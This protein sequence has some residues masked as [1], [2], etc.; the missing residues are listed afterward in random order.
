[1]KYSKNQIKK[2]GKIFKEKLAASEE[3][4]NFAAEVL[5]YWRIIHGQAIINFQ[6][7][8]IENVFDVDDKAFIAKR[9]KRTPS[10]IAKLKRL[11]HIQLSTM[12]DIAG[13]RVVVSSLTHLRKLVKILKSDSFG[14][15]LKGEDDY[16]SN[17]KESGYRGIH[18]IYK[19]KDENVQ[20]LDGLIIEVQVR[21]HKQHA[22]ATA[23][24]TMGTYLNSHLKFNEGKPKWLKYFALTSSAF[25][26]IEKTKPV[27]QY[28]KLTE[29]ETYQQAVY[30][31]KYN[32][33]KESLEAFSLVSNFICDETRKDHKY[34]LI[35][36][37]IKERI[38]E[39][40]SYR[41]D[42]LEDANKDYTEFEGKYE[43]DSNVQIVLVS[44]DTIQEL[45]EAYPNYFLDTKEFIRNMKLIEKR[46]N[47]LKTKIY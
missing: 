28:N 15:E 43:T 12:Q 21:T 36:L 7:K 32:E 41:E 33:I 27:P 18:L 37:K 20:E 26:Y 46:F 11:N 30:E 29:Y 4:N 5:T 31:Y 17:P 14:H 25:A 47:K 42:L 38:V 1:M 35:I 34:H 39:I 45:R 19:Y 23:V 6:D 24:E 13:I 22:W 16:L 2:A 10:I 9:L 3:D 44:T 8:I 40:S